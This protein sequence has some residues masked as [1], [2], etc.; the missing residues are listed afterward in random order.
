MGTKISEYCCFLLHVE[1]NSYEEAGSSAVTVLEVTV[2][3]QNKK[4]F[5]H[6]ISSQWYNIV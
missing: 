4:T 6:H 3:T 5:K 2:Q 1:N